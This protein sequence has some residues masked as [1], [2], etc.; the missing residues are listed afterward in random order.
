MV[1][2]KNNK[3]IF[4]LFIV[5]LWPLVACA[6]YWFGGSMDSFIIG[7]GSFSWLMNV[8]DLLLKYKN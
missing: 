4:F 3:I 6:Y 2:M 8:L 5:I 7:F 1:I